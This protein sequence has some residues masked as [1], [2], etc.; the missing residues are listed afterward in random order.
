[1]KSIQYTPYRSIG[2]YFIRCV[3]LILLGWAY[4]SIAQT[5]VT[6]ALKWKCY[7]KRGS[8]DIELVYQVDGTYLATFVD[9]LRQLMT[10]PECEIVAI[11]VEANATPT[12]DMLYNERLANQRAQNI[13][14]YILKESG[15]PA[16]R[17]SAY[18]MGFDR[19]ELISKLNQSDLPVRGEL[20]QLI[21]QNADLRLLE[22][23]L[24]AHQGGASWRW[25]ETHLFP[26]MAPPSASLICYVA[27]Q[28]MQPRGEET[29]PYQ[30]KPWL[31]FRSNLL[32]PLLNVG[33]ELPIGNRWS[34]GAD[35]YYPWLWRD[36]LGNASKKSCFELLSAGMDIRYWLG[37]RHEAGEKNWQYRL[38]GQAIGLYGYWGYYDLGHN[39]KGWQGDY[40][41]VGVDYT[42]ALAIGKRKRWRLAFNL[43]VG[44]LH[45]AAEEYKVYN[46]KG[47]PFRT[48][49]KKQV[50]W[51]GPTKAA[52][53]L[54]LPIYKKVRKE[55][56]P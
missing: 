14:S 30:K 45:S 12:K 3:L 11:Y 39:F 46:E 16:K 55:V 2:Q 24:K 49:V 43:G 47:H 13:R 50:N 6:H 22:E 26:E 8:A 33:V 54:S 32:L 28:Q 21:Q 19:E 10:Q 37:R 25:M 4:P 15:I 51:F 38:T 35:W 41:H 36:W 29:L 27:T 53:S 5:K 18:P 42:Y 44:Y 23:A 52:I 56:R 7:F 20:I 34:M 40:Y 17:I 9:S 48:G 1:M 31:A